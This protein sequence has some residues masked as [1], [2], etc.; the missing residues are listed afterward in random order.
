MSDKNEPTTLPLASSP[1]GESTCDA[2]GDCCG[3]LD[4]RDFIRLA[5]LGAA[6][7]ALATGP[8]AGAT[9]QD[10][11]AREALTDPDWPTFK[12]YGPDFVERIALPLGGIGTGTVSLTG[13]GSLRDWELMNRPAKG[14]TPEG[15]S[16]PLFAVFVED[17]GQRFCRLAEGPLPVQEYEASHGSEAPNA[18]LPRF[19][20]CSFAGG[21][22]FGRVL[23]SDDDLPIDVHIK[24]FNPMI[25]ADADASGIPVAALTYELRNKTNRTLRA[26]VAGSLPNF[27]GMDAWETERDWK[28]DRVPS[29]ARGNRNRFMEG[30][31]IRGILM[32]SSGVR[33]TAPSWGTLALVT[34]SPGRVTFRTQWLEARWGSGV[35]DFWDDFSA[36]G[37][38]DERPATDAANPSAS[39]AVELE[40][41]AGG[42]VDVPFL[43]TWHFPNRYSWSR[44]EA[45]WSA[46]DRIGNYY[47]SQYRD[48]WDVAE[49]TAPVIADLQRR[50]AKFV[51]TFLDSDLP[52]EVKEAALFNTS[53]L[54]TQTC[55]RTPD[56]RFFGWEGAADN[57]GC[58][59]GSC[60][61][62]WNYEQATAF[63]YGD[64]ALT[65]REVEFAHAT[66]ED[67]VMS[68]RVDLPLERARDYGKAAADGQMGS[69][70]KMYREWQLSGNDALLRELWP[71]VRRALEFCWIPGGWDADRDGV[72]EGA[73]H[74]TMDVEY[75]GPNPQMGFWY[76]GALR[77]AEQMARAVGEPDFADECEAMFERG[78]AWLDEHLFDGEYYQHRVE[79]PT[80]PSQI[81]P[82]LLIGM[83]SEDFGNPDF[84]L[85]AGCLVDQLVGQFMAHVCGLGY[86]GKPDNIKATLESIWKYNRR[87]HLEDHF[88]SMRT[89]A[90]AG[91]SAILMASYP[92]G[93]PKKP[94]S[95]FSEV[96]TG[97]EYTAAVGMLQEGLTDQ[98]LRAIRDVR[99]RYDGRKRSPYD[100]A[101]CG[102]H[103]ARAMAVWA[104]VLALTGFHY[105]GVTRTMTLASPPGR[106][107]WSNGYAWGECAI[108]ANADVRL[109]VV[110]GTLPLERFVLGDVGEHAFASGH[111][112]A[113]GA[114]SDFRVD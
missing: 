64:L 60:T 21:Y 10:A 103:Y 41:P 30:R 27:I 68:F 25:P 99:E 100:E 49:R 92:K 16:T 109:S 17:G 67:G 102:H 36:D 114:T 105:S 13:F 26:A 90:L 72:M 39:L 23:L 83:G 94:F 20:G 1:S 38:L 6:T 73:Q 65:M 88:N 101:E 74:N 63:L 59:H 31:G 28:G 12:V 40:V 95:Y 106:H 4:R 45:E 15:A 87:E 97:F 18:R 113:A 69:I 57:R 43:L 52:D 48:A 111:T 91:E 56:G 96:M 71:K 89:F 24:A 14:F 66:D 29:G 50:S 19:P 82:S 77:A 80:D 3:G 42:R 104:A 78:S 33:D 110:E 79:P 11:A 58:C 46:V 112:L 54:R 2:D 9:A 86:L 53:T 98:G 62:V 37:R 70:M 51:R 7:T 107:F 32:D 34:T 35:L 93:R 81:A 85:A 76:L 47:T 5:G 44:P 61:H 8:A 55:F 22:P 108:G 84:Q 75:Y